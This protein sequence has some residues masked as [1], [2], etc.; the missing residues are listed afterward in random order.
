VSY[1]P[2]I[3]IL[4]DFF[5]K[6]A[7]LSVLGFAAIIT[8]A[9]VG[10]SGWN[11]MVKEKENMEKDLRA[12][13]GKIQMPN[14][15][16]IA[17]LDHL[18]ENYCNPVTNIA[19]SE[20]VK[21]TWKRSDTTWINENYKRS[22]RE[23]EMAKNDTDHDHHDQPA[24]QGRIIGGEITHVK[25]YPFYV[26]LWN[27]GIHICGASILTKDMILTAAHC[28]Y[29]IVNPSN[30][31]AFFGVSSRDEILK[32]QAYGHNI[33]ASRIKTT[34]LNPN[35]DTNSFE[36]DNAIL[37]LE[38]PI[39][40]WSDFIMPA[41]IHQKDKVS[42][43]GPDLKPGMEVEIVGM[44]V[45]EEGSSEPSDYLENIAVAMISNSDCNKYFGSNWMLKDMIC[46]GHLLG[47]KDACQG[48][49][50]G[51]LIQ[52]ALVE[53]TP[54]EWLVGV[55]SFGVGCARPGL[56]GAYSSIDYY[57][58]WIADTVNHFKANHQ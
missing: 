27:N 40:E 43:D 19:L 45:E 25:Q 18:N 21:Y 32:K 42:V 23:I 1:R 17:A 8:F 35:W 56:G 11:Q 50:G 54:I 26:A 3:P 13:N 47:G 24:F 28:V 10:L 53:G 15:S 20:T 38:V 46:A 2:K 49:S 37:E 33:H 51:P 58:Q 39:P 6:K 36:G 31:E 5:S 48:D 34:I 14:P 29:N 30:M 52:T 4:E 9:A 41:C 22:R 16:T 7:I 44:G 57:S 55:V 12:C